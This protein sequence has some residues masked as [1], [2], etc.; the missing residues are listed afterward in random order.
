MI[1]ATNNNAEQYFNYGCFYLLHPFYSLQP[2][3]KKSSELSHFNLTY[4]KLYKRTKKRTKKG[5][6]RGGG[7]GEGKGIGKI[8]LLLLEKD[9]WINKGK[10]SITISGGVVRRRGCANRSIK[11]TAI[12]EAWSPVRSL[13]SL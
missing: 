5:S 2:L 4:F 11:L 9:N 10:M 13:G 6:E 12:A 3:P 8:K 7:Q 1:K